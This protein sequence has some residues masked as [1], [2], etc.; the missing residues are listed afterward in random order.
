MAEDYE[1]AESFTGDLDHKPVHHMLV[2]YPDPIQRRLFHWLSSWF[3]FFVVAAQR[4]ASPAGG[5]RKT[6]CS[7]KAF[8]NNHNPIF[9]QPPA[10]QVQAVLGS[11]GNNG[12]K[13]EY[14]TL[15]TSRLF[16]TPSGKSGYISPARDILAPILPIHN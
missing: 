1:M 13:S 6:S 4:R 5:E 3:L 7:S 11:M 15:P 2:D 12:T 9:A 10:R 8:S 14:L 16:F